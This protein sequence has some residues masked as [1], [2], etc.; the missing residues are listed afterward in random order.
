M[1]GPIY[2]AVRHSSAVNP[3]S[4]AVTQV[5]PTTSQFSGTTVASISRSE[6]KYATKH[7][8]GFAVFTAFLFLVTLVF[9][10]LIQIGNVS[11]MH[12]LGE[13]YFFKID[14]S[15]LVPSNVQNAKAMN[16]VLHQSGLK[17]FYQIGLWN[18]C[19]GYN[20]Q[21][22]TACSKP[23]LL[24]WFNPVQIFLDE[25]ME[26]ATSKSTPSFTPIKSFKNSS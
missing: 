20:N 7:R 19:E 17:D 6:L 15:H 9:L 10:I 5:S 23:S 24:F 16:N 11:N 18:F 4:T 22:I 26:G 3:N 14:V 21:G 1:T 13:L 8:K 12:V 25:L 2:N